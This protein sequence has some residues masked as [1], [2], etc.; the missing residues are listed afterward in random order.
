M[1]QDEIDEES[2][3]QDFV[4]LGFTL[5]DARVYFSLIQLG[6]S[7]PV[8]LAEECGVDRSRVYDSLRRLSKKGYV[9]EE[10][11]KRGPLYKAKN[12][13]D[14]LRALRK[15]FRSKNELSSALE[16][17]LEQYKPISKHPFLASINGKIPIFKEILTLISQAEEYIKILLTPDYSMNLEF[18]TQIANALVEKK[19]LKS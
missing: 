6:P 2:I 17:T 3:I 1:E 19:N 13:H 12:P 15:E 9:T 7:K 5:N 10:P 18:L 4:S 14:I 8:K 16:K 11:V